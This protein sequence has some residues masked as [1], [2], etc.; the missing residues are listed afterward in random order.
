[1]STPD[2]RLINECGILPAPAHEANRSAPAR[3][4][5]RV[6]ACWSELVGQCALVS[7]CRLRLSVSASRSRPAGRTS[8]VSACRL[9]RAR[10]CLPVGACW[11]VP[12]GQ[13]VRQCLP[14]SASS[15]VP[16]GWGLS[17]SACWSAPAGRGLLASVGPPVPGGQCL[18]VSAC[19]PVPVGRG[20]LASEGRQTLPVRACSSM[21]A[22]DTRQS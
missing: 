9:A 14:V 10:Q 8:L 15:S 18:S 22:D 20:P 16:A 7:A 19:G 17:V 13:P 5:L 4:C 1:M 11:S 21:L 2:Y 3:Q 6:G 12:V